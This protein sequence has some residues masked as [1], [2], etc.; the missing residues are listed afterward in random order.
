MSMIYSTH[1]MLEASNVA[2]VVFIASCAMHSLCLSSRALFTLNLYVELVWLLVP[3]SVVVLLI[4]RV[5]LLQCAEED[6]SLQALRIHVIRASA[7]CTASATSYCRA[8]ATRVVW[9]AT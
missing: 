4:A 8:V 9:C 6:V 3:T 2:V 7:N 1:A 5:V